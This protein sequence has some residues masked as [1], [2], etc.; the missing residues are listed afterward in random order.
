MARAVR[1]GQSACHANRLVVEWGDAEGFVVK[2]LLRRIVHV[3]KGDRVDNL[4]DRELLDLI[5]SVE[6]EGDT[7]KPVLH[8]VIVAKF[9][10]CVA[11][12]ARFIF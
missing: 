8:L 11:H 1:R 6:A 3:V 10:S 9:R 7:G 2:T 4:S 5:V 12:T